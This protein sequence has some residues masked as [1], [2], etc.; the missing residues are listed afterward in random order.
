MDQVCLLLTFCGL[1]LSSRVLV[2]TA[3]PRDVSWSLVS[4]Q[5]PGVWPE[6]VACS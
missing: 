5:C 4:G 2:E 6:D 1:E 3:E